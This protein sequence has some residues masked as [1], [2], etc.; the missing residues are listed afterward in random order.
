MAVINIT[1]IA[2]IRPD[3][4]ALII[5]AVPPNVKGAFLVIAA[6]FAFDIVYCRAR[7]IPHKNSFAYWVAFGAAVIGTVVF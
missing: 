4:G 2:N 1:D 3:A 7:K 6:A 5:P